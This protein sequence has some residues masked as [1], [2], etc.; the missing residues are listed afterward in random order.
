MRTPLAICA[1]GLITSSSLYVGACS[2]GTEDSAQAD[3]SSADGAALSDSGRSE[4]DAS[5]TTDSSTL[6]D[7]PGDAQSESSDAAVSKAAYANDFSSGTTAASVGLAETPPPGLHKFNIPLQ[8]LNGS[9]RP[10]S[11]GAGYGDCIVFP[12]QNDI[13]PDHF[14]RAKIDVGPGGVT[15]KVGAYTGVSVRVSQTDY[16]WYKMETCASATQVRFV[17][18]VNSAIIAETYY[19]FSIAPNTS[20]DFYLEAKGST[21]TGKINGQTIFTRTDTT[22]TAGKPGFTM[23]NDTTIDQTLVDSYQAGSL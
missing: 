12:A 10:S 20:Y 4:S 15:G 6:S 21:I 14:S 9:A 3:G 22:L 16:S 2:D 18:L 5:S 7:A 19:N 23:Y 17:K 8:I 11:F 1:L 13:L